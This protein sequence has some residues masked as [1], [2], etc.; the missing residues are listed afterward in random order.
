VTVI[1]RGGEPVWLERTGSKGAALS[2][3]N[4][5]SDQTGSLGVTGRQNAR[6]V[7]RAEAQAQGD[8]QER[9]ALCDAPPRAWVDNSQIDPLANLAGI[10][11]GSAMLDQARQLL[12]FDWVAPPIL[13]RF[14]AFALSRSSVSF[15]ACWIAKVRKGENAKRTCSQYYDRGQAVRPCVAM[16]A[17][18][19]QNSR[20]N[21]TRS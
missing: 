11:F 13:S 19:E 20:T 16:D 18:G 5:R 9:L 7:P 12:S 14:Q 4:G 10:G 2:C 17:T 1:N 15:A 3:K 21:S 6:P 8:G